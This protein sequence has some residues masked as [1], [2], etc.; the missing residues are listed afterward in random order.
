MTRAKTSFKIQFCAMLSKSCWNTFYFDYICW[1]WCKLSLQFSP[2][3]SSTCTISPSGKHLNQ[4]QAEKT[5]RNFSF[6]W[7][8]FPVHISNEFRFLKNT[9]NSVNLTAITQFSQLGILIVVHWN[10]FAKL[11]FFSPHTM[12]NSLKMSNFL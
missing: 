11:F 3:V 1:L 4:T 6:I 8:I 7:F 12:W 10:T 5:P 9:L 2:N